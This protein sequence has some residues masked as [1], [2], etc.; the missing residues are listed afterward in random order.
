MGEEARV[1]RNARKR[2]VLAALIV[3]LASVACGTTHESERVEEDDDTDKAAEEGL[4]D[5]KD[6]STKD[7]SKP[8][9]D[10]TTPTEDASEPTKDASKPDATT[11]DK[12]ASVDPPSPPADGGTGSGATYTEH[13]RPLLNRTCVPCHSTGGAGPFSLAT[14]AEAKGKAAQIAR[15]TKA[16]TM[17][18]TPLDNSG[19]CNT[20]KDVNWL[21]DAEIATIESWSAAGAPEGPALAAPPV[22]ELPK[23][24][25]EIKSIK[26]PVYTPKM[27]Q[28]DDYRCFVIKSPFTE[29]TFVTGFDTKP[30]NKEV[31]HH[32]VIF[33]PM[34]DT[35]ALLGPVLDALDPGPGYECFG[36]PG[37]PATMLA[38]WTP[39]GG[40]TLYPDKLGVEVSPNRPIIVQMH[41]STA[42][43]DHP[44]EDSTQIDFQ[45]Q[46]EGISAGEYVVL[47]DLDMNL[48]PGQ[49]DAEEL[50]KLKLGDRMGG[51]TTPVQV[52][53]VYPH[54][55]DLGKTIRVT[56]KDTAGKETCVTDVP[57]YKF[58]WQGL[59]F[60]D[61][62]ITLNPSDEI[63]LRCGF[64][65]TTRT[66]VTKW[67]ES[68]KDEMCVT[69]LFVRR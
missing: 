7:A 60:F 43:T 54:M 29:K 52:Y 35:L 58:S 32:M 2:A 14:F 18:P 33:Y 6:A 55:H 57:R 64:D 10:A 46:K 15:A 21:T 11:P 1:G 34:D 13:V 20:Y 69:G 49:K 19:T 23:L 51:R 39:G 40:A 31:A 63:N 44:G 25:G 24:T 3:S 38:A 22:R 53:G 12:D 30:G 28:K 17:P 4:T 59:Y 41:Y 42:H 5:V 56:A 48:P 50:I 9:K 61:K 67:G 62:P 37:V 36:S 45:V 65:T 8:A 68:T 26:T 27:G 16:R 47:L 66:E